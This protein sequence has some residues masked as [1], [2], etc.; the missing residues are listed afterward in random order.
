[1]LEKKVDIYYIKEELKG[2]WNPKNQL[3]E[4]I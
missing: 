4:D 3:Q 2:Y 1:M